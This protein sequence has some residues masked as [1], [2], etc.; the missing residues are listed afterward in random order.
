MAQRLG[1]LIG[2][3]VALWAVLVYPASR[4]LGSE[5][6]IH[7][8]AAMLLCLIPAVATMAFALRAFQRSSEEQL[9]AVLGGTGLRMAVVLGLGFLAFTF[10][11]ELHADAFWIWLIVFYLATLGLEMTL[12][13]RGMSAK[14]V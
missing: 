9:L 4:L 14:Q 3:T 10:V 11:P 5:A 8:L 6:L 7:S 12:L 2:G 13:V 1:L